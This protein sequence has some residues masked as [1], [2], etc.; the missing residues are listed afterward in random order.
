VTV[1]VRGWLRRLDETHQK[2]TPGVWF[3]WDRGVGWHLCTEDP[4]A[5]GRGSVP[6]TLP[7]GMRTDLARGEDAAAIV[8]DHNAVPA[9]VAA[10]TAVLDLADEWDGQHAD[11]CCQKGCPH[12]GGGHPGPVEF[13]TDG[14]LR[15]IGPDYP[16]PGD[17]TCYVGPFRDAV[18]AAVAAPLAGH[19][20]EEDGR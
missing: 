10:L 8:S 16:C 3:A 19:D 6:A 9:L 13:T 5:V 20:N 15:Q 4:A 7:E 11:W 14:G 12:F 17:C 2:A 1:D 18:R